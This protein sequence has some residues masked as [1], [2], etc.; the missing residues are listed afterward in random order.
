MER[1]SSRRMAIVP[2]PILYALIPPDKLLKRQVTGVLVL[3]P[4]SI[5][6]GIKGLLLSEKS[7]VA[8]LPTGR[9]DNFKFFPPLL[10]FIL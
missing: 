10:I 6:L 7:I 2:E 5:S 1:A 8:V 3:M 4:I 9:S